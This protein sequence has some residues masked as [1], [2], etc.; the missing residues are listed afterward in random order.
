[1]LL[2]LSHSVGLPGQVRLC[3]LPGVE[4]L[5]GWQHRVILARE[6]AVSKNLTL[7]QEAL[8]EYLEKCS[9]AVD[10]AYVQFLDPKTKDVENALEYLNKYVIVG[11][12]TDMEE[13]FQRW[14]KVALWTCRDHPRMATI[15]K[16]LS[17]PANT[18]SHYRESTSLAN[19]TTHEL[20][21]PTIDELDLDLQQLIRSLTADDQLI[22]QRA[23]E[24]YEE[25]GQWFELKKTL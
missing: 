16:A 13:T 11:M 7:Y 24:L 20:A 22:F 18:D 23:K 5:D 19:G 14:T 8:R 25:Q 10:N 3:K 2:C 12:Q 9:H 17:D 15:E 21:S 6:A 4:D 1:M